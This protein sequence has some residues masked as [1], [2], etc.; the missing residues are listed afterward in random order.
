MPSLTANSAHTDLASAADIVLAKTPPYMTDP[1]LPAGFPLIA[2]LL[3]SEGISTRIVR[4]LEDPRDVPAAVLDAVQPT[5]IGDPTLAE[6]TARMRAVAEANPAFFD[7]L[8]ARVL[9]GPQRVFGFSVWRDNVDVLL[10][11][12]PRLKAARPEALVILGGPET[13]ES[14]EELRLDCVDVIVKGAAE[15]VVVP[16]MQAL[17]D[18]RPAAA[19]RYEDVWVHPRHAPGVHLHRL[20]PEP[21]PLPRIDYRGIVPLVVGDPRP[22]LPVLLNFG[23][24]YH[25]G[26]CVN[27]V[28]YPSMLWGS[29]HR[30]LEELLE[31][32]AMWKE[33]F[34]ENAPPL[35][36]FFT[37]AA[38]N[39]NS[40]QFDAL[41]RL[42]RDASWP[43]R[44]TSIS[45][46]VVIDGR[47]NDERARLLN[48]AGF[49]ELYFGLETASQR[50]RRVIK[51]PGRIEEVAKGIEAIAR[52]EQRTFALDCG[53]IVGFPDET[54]EEFHESIAFLEWT[55]S[56]D[57]FRTLIVYVPW[58]TP[59]AMNPE[60]FAE[61]QG[62]RKGLFWHAPT[63]AGQP[64]TRARRL[65]YVIEHFAHRGHTDSLTV[66]SELIRRM[67][68]PRTSSYWHEW[69]RRHGGVLGLTP[70][71][72]RAGT[73]PAYGKKQD[74][75]AARTHATTAATPR[76]TQLSPLLE[77][78]RADLDT[79]LPSM[80]PIAGADATWRIE[81]VEAFDGNAEIAEIRFE[82][83]T[84]DR[85]MS[86]LVGPRD[87][88]RSAF[89]RTL[90]FNLSYRVQ[91]GFTFDPV[92][93]D[94]VQRFVESSGRA[95]AEE[96]RRAP[97]STEP[98]GDSAVR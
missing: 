29:E 79:R 71:R 76:P 65:L 51:K 21:P 49:T 11:L 7:G 15:A 50:L 86:V 25:C 96:T 52:L 77:P 93:M 33:L 27:K 67:L 47:M 3:R 22:F 18:G 85:R 4:F 64:A 90:L 58:R 87:E 38:L 82:A 55:D 20:R 2:S 1:W 63:V 40:E 35:G 43:I 5:M 30:V 73:T 61:A 78:L 41:C 13:A 24:P 6:R 31:I 97:V 8:L 75:Q 48:D 69:D 88:E 16:V 45:G 57:V 56:L 91:N 26:F 10:E 62:D 94:S 32:S 37:D 36:I 72:V 23:C 44:P 14:Y 74:D 9:E 28:T 92:V 95:P 89:V 53:V 98:L 17:L 70:K 66:P 12:L 59:A 81:R 46:L 19:A 42:L 80:E 39:A 68:D 54:E 84:D 60:L 83:L 34:P